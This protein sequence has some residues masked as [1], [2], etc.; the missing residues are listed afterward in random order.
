M[1]KISKLSRNQSG[2]EKIMII[3]VECQ[4]GKLM[5]RSNQRSDLQGASNDLHGSICNYYCG[6]C[7]NS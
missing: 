7:G 5:K 6:N 4:K 3:G 1:G 2:E